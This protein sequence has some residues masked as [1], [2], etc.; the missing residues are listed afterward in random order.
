MHGKKAVTFNRNKKGTHGTQSGMHTAH[1]DLKLE[2]VEAQVK[3]CF[4]LVN[5]WQTAEVYPQLKCTIGVPVVN[6]N[7]SELVEVVNYVRET[8]KANVYGARI[9]LETPWNLRLIRQLA[10]STSDREVV[11]FMTYGWSLN[12][13]GRPTSVT[14]KNHASVDRFLEAMQK[15]IGKELQM[16]CLLGPFITLPWMTEVA[17]SPMSTRPKKDSNDRQIIMD[18]SWL[19]NGRSVND[20]ISKEKYLGQDMKLQYPTIDRL[21]RRATQLRP[22]AKGYKIDM[23]RAF[24]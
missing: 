19:H 22:M 16:G 3:N 21:C 5:P 9:P 15:Y 13:D 18:M 1:V 6:G 23:D 24:K 12:H 14:L 11:E 10:T 17:V 20:G 7:I 4:K 8:G 2:V